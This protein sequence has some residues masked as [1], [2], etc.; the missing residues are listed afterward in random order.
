MDVDVLLSTDL[1]T[2]L[3]DDVGFMVPVDEVRIILLHLQVRN[4]C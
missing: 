1:D 2:L 3:E 4:L